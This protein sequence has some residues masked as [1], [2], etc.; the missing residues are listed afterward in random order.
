MLI[1][2]AA[3]HWPKDTEK[4]TSSESV[5]EIKNSRL[6]TLFAI[7]FQPVSQSLSL[8]SR[9]NGADDRG[10]RR[11]RCK[12]RRTRSFAVIS[13]QCDLLLLLEIQFV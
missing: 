5:F 7:G 11:A 2:Q 3:E 1:R 8:S 12:V 10:S 6:K 9:A 4:V 13:E